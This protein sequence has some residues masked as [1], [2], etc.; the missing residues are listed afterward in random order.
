[1][2]FNINVQTKDGKRRFTR[3]DITAAFGESKYTREL[4]DVNRDERIVPSEIIPFFEALERNTKGTVGIEGSIVVTDIHHDYS[5]V[6]KRD[7]VCTTC[8]S[9]DAPFYQSMYL[10]VP[11]ME[12]LFYMPVKGTVLAAM[13]SSIALNFFLLGETKARWSDIRAVVG[14]R[15]DARGELVRELGFKWIDIVGFFLSLAVLFFVCIHIV[16]RV[17][18]KR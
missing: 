12:G 16:L 11:E 14:A 13:P 6:Q 8:H 2:V 7:K 4:I 17:V 15:G 18:F 1:M 9:N 5:Q 10:V 3:D